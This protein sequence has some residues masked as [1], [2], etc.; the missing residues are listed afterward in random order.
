MG[1]PR[2]AGPPPVSLP[3]PATLL[4][5][6]DEVLAELEA[7][8]ASYIDTLVPQCPGIP[9][10]NLAQSVFGRAGGHPR[11]ELEILTKL[12]AAP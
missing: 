7:R 3:P 9:R 12:E 1:R 6:L 2:K 11:A 8:K 10:G 5:R 4:A